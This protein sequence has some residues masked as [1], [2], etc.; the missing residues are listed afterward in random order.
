MGRVRNAPKLLF[1]K[2]EGKISLGRPKHRW[3]DTLKWIFK[4][5]SWMLWIGVIWLSVSPMTDSY[6][7]G[8]EYF[9]SMQDG[10]FFIC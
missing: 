10:N 5:L 8:N 9:G 6:E 2:P 7:H 3:K 1:G 4:K